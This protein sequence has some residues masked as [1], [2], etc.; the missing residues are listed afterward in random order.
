MNTNLQIPTNKNAKK[1]LG[2]LYP[3]LSFD[4]VGLCY[5]VHNEI[6]K[7]SR[8]KQYADLLEQKLKENGITYKREL[9]IGDTNNILD[10]LIE[11][12]IILELKAKPFV[13]SGDYDQIQRYL[14]ATGIQLGIIVNFGGTY[15]RSHRVIRVAYGA[16][17]PGESDS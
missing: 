14:Q 3:D 10:F 6:G 1:G 4:M 11:D 5:T 8:E 17:K 12:K 13:A 15:V 7:F 2:L 9:R 16:R